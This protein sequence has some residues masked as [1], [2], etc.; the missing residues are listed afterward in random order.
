MSAPCFPIRKKAPP[1][2]IIVKN[3]VARGRMLDNECSSPCVFLAAEASRRIR[4][5]SPVLA[6]II[7][8][9]IME[10]RHDAITGDYFAARWRS[11]RSLEEAEMY[12]SSDDVSKP[13]LVQNSTQC[14][15]KILRRFRSIKKTKPISGSKHQFQNRRLR[16]EAEKCEI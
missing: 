5:W 12:Q 7:A 6:P 8:R 9:N 3:S 4:S 10:P 13:P 14:T 1:P 11:I 15:I 16:T 2:F